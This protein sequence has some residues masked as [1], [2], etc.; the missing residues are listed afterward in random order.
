MNSLSLLASCWIVG[1]WEV[2]SGKQGGEEESE[3][4]AFILLA[5]ILLGLCGLAAF[6][7]VRLPKAAA[8]WVLGSGDTPLFTSS[9]LRVAMKLPKLPTI[10]TLVAF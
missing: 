4:W 9:G 1:Q 8:P 5:P 2:P 10:A 3:I 7:S 6:L